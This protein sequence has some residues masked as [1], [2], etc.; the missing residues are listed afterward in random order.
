MLGWG[1][2][3]ANPEIIEKWRAEFIAL[4]EKSKTYKPI[5]L[6]SVD[7]IFVS[8]TVES[9]WQGFLIARESV[10]IKLPDCAD[11]RYPKTYRQAIESLIKEQGYR[12]RGES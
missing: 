8:N 4:L 6:S 11:I 10:V 5:Y 7:G 1:I 12:V 9:A 2:S 3:M